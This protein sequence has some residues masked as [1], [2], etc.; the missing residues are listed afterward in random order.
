MAIKTQFSSWSLLAYLET[1]TNV[2]KTNHWKLYSHISITIFIR[3]LLT[4]YYLNFLHYK[5]FNYIISV[6]KTENSYTMLLNCIVLNVAKKETGELSL[7]STSRAEVP[8]KIRVTFPASI[9]NTQLQNIPRKSS[10]FNNKLRHARIKENAFCD[11]LH[12]TLISTSKLIMYL[13]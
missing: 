13:H 10:S 4:F 5:T 7:R 8:H 11:T 3:L 1:H 2:L 12:N 6:R 9:F